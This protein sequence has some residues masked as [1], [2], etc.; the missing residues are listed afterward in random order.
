VAKEELEMTRPRQ[1]D[2]VIATSRKWYEDLPERLGSQTGKRFHLIKDKAEL[3]LSNLRGINPRYVFF[4]HWSS[5]IPAEIFENFECVI[6]HMTDLPFGRGGSPLQNLISQGIQQTKISALRCSA[7]ID[8]GP[9]YL[10]RD[11]DL[12]GSAH[13]IFQRA[14]PVIE[15][16]ILEIVRNEPT[17]NEQEGQP[18]YFKRRTPAQSDIKEISTIERLYDHIRMLDCEGY[19]HAFLETGSFRLEFSQVQKG[20]SGLSCQ[21]QIVPKRE[22]AESSSKEGRDEK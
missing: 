4:P 11:F 18:T 12:M 5:L 7:E 3:T 10:K 8:A 6:F 22:N 1:T 21:V 2:Y 20:D 9:I 13:E 17:P 14:V 19:P 16:M 15:G